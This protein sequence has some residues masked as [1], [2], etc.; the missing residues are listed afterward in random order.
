MTGRICV[1][2]G[3]AGVIPQEGK[4]AARSELKVECYLLIYMVKHV[5]DDRVQKMKERDEHNNAKKQF[6]SKNHRRPVETSAISCSG[7][8]SR[9]TIALPVESVHL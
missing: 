1:T 5:R 3:S 2:G 9:V 7:Q 4:S 8:V 6:Q